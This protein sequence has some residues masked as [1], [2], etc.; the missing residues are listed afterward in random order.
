LL[1]SGFKVDPSGTLNSASQLPSDSPQ[2]IPASKV[3]VTFTQTAFIRAA[4]ITAN[5]F[6]QSDYVDAGRTEEIAEEIDIFTGTDAQTAMTTLWQDFGKCASFSYP[7][8]GTTASTRLT[9]SQLPGVGDFAI[10]AV[11][12]SP[13]FRGGTTLVA[14]RAGSQIITTLYS[15]GGSDLG[16]P[17]VGWAEQIAQRLRAAK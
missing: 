8:N 3:C 14:V 11:L 17:A 7:S 4:G 13:I 10:K 15:S 12:V 2:P 9:R 16:S 6:A 5:D 1:P